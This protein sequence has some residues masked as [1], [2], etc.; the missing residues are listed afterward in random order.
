MIGNIPNPLQSFQWGDSGQAMTP[1]QVARRRAMA[2]LLQQDSSSTAP[3][4]HWT[5]AAARGL[6]GYLSGRSE[7]I[8]TRAEN[9]GLASADEAVAGNPILSALMG[10]QGQ[11]L[12]QGMPAQSSVGQALM[13]SAPTMAQEARVA[14]GADAVR[15]G[16][17]QRG[18]PPHVADAFV[19]NFQ[20]ESGLNPGIN[21]IEPLVPGSRGGFGL[22]QWTGPRRRQL[23]AFAQQT[24][25]P[26]SDVDTQLDFLMT[27][28]QGSEA[29]A[30][31]S[32]LSAPDAGSA[33]AAIVNNFLRP[34]EEHRARRVAEYTGGGGGVSTNAA[35]MI[36][37]PAQAPSGVVA[38]LAQAQANPWVAQK[39][40]PVI[41]ALMGQEIG[42]QDAAYQQSLQQS[43]PFYQAQLQGQ[44]IANQ[45]AM[46][47]KPLDP[48]ANVQEI[49]GQ[50]VQMGPAGPQVIGD[51]RTADPGYTTLSQQE[52]QGMGLD[53]SKIYQRGPD[54]KVSE[55]GGGGV[56]VNNNMPGQDKFDEAFAA[57]DAATLGTMTE[58]GMAAQR[59]LPRIDQL[60][61]LLAA[62]PSGME[63]VVKQ[64]AGEWGINTEGLDTIQ[65]AQAIINSLVPEQRQP[66]SGPMSDADLA[67]FKQ[68]LPRLINQPGGNAQIIATM[69]AI[70][71]Y[72]AEGAAITQSVRDGSMTRA[73]GFA[74]LQNRVNPLA[75]FTAP[76]G[77]G[78][79]G[80]A[81][82]PPQPTSRAE[83]DALPSGTRFIAPDGSVRSKP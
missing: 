82:A 50:L 76:Q 41:E 54:G 28:L 74:A 57:G 63:A 44:Q 37:A 26:V 47:P 79:I 10:D 75:N 17:V 38:A 25:R 13:P 71:Q 6:G 24:G 43:D 29:G 58:A 23:E 27:E 70:A 35:G 73:E 55:I 49:N 52:A 51:Y 32:I 65:A 42:R 7:R 62:G 68:S 21:E 5:Q 33:A 67:L 1:E 80:D 56:T 59:N 34:A 78:T 30:A 81:S 45:Q 20:D 18:L 12:A 3:V 19:M 46:T 77:P 14:P 8:A 64:R 36:Q 72:D 53:P 66:G 4:A 83:Y 60:E 9:E 16:L 11:M 2:A 40:G 22:A 61:Q 39:Y 69:R 48:W 31:R 15:A